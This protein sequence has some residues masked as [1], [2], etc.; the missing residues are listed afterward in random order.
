[1][2]NPP[3]RLMSLFHSRMFSPLSLKSRPESEVSPALSAQNPETPQ[4]F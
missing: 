4:Y 1:M 2:R 3:L